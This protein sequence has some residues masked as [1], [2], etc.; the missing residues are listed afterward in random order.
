MIRFNIVLFTLFC[1]IIP[2][3]GQQWV[4]ATI[5]S[6][7]GEFKVSC[8]VLTTPLRGTGKYEGQDLTLALWQMIFSL[9]EQQDIELE[10]ELLALSESL[11]EKWGGDE[12]AVTAETL[13]V[14]SPVWNAWDGDAT[15]VDL[16]VSDD[17][18]CYSYIDWG[19]HFEKITDRMFWRQQFIQQCI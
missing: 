2:V 12:C 10:G 17:A 16:V 4:E 1:L 8:E 7:H 19:R 15:L 3:S 5:G 14:K 13:T 18:D 9:M 11:R 6:E